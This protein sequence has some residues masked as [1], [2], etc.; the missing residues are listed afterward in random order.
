MEIPNNRSEQDKHYLYAYLIEII[1]AYEEGAIKAS[2]KMP[3]G[4]KNAAKV[5]LWKPLQGIEVITWSAKNSLNLVQD[6][7][8]D[9]SENNEPKIGTARFGLSDGSDTEQGETGSEGGT[10]AGTTPSPCD[11]DDIDCKDEAELAERE[12]KS[13]SISAVWDS[14]GTGWKEAEVCGYAPGVKFEGIDAK[15]ANTGKW[16][17]EGK[18]PPKW[19][20]DAKFGSDKKL[21]EDPWFM[22]KEMAENYE[23]YGD[24]LED[25]W[26]CFLDA[27]LSWEFPDV[28]LLAE[29]D[30]LLKQL[31]SL[32]DWIWDR[33]NPID[34]AKEICK[35]LDLLWNI[36][37]LPN[38]S[39]FLAAL[40]GLLQKY[41]I[42]GLSLRL[43][44]TGL[45]GPLVKMILDSLCSI[46][47]Q[48]VAIAMAPIKCVLNGL[49]VIQD[50]M[51]Q[52]AN[53]LN[54]TNQFWNYYVT[55]EALG[56]MWTGKENNGAVYGTKGRG[57]NDASW[58]EV[59]SGKN[60]SAGFDGW[61]AFG[62]EKAYKAASA[63][64]QTG[65]L[66]GWNPFPDGM[67]T[68]VQYGTKDT[69][70]KAAK[71]GD[72]KFARYLQVPILCL[73]EFIE[74]IQHMAKNIIYALKSLSSLLQ[75]QL[76]FSI[77]QSGLIMMV[78]D[79]IALIMALMELASHDWNC[80]D[81]DTFLE[82]LS[83][84]LNR[85]MSDVE[86]KPLTA[87]GDTH[88]GG[89]HYEGGESAMSN[90]EHALSVRSVGGHFEDVIEIN[91]CFHVASDADSQK[92]NEKFTQFF[93]EKMG[94]F[95]YE[96][97]TP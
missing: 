92:L 14:W 2:C 24:Y 51:G 11:D 94:P 81:M 66:Q 25:C 20:F 85:N 52:T 36:F 84:C 50:L 54:T 63:T 13:G 37:C 49:R 79:L 75:G 9:E 27:G 86:S 72:L 1:N 53:F 32:L 69:A 23:T 21:P 74:W 80:D 78:L 56:N 17:G 33:L 77:L 89:T 43:D 96:G 76:S 29:V 97:A 7:P 65:T 58:G 30:K 8:V 19:E 26:N 34:L 87:T 45:I 47:E 55:Q 31:E 83:E 73:Q 93:N 46:L 67:V 12:S 16:W 3:K 35:W 68:G 57:N 28:N 88:E 48:L 59:F 42:N 18:D 40:A 60:A 44:W 4:D 5:S 41:M 90:S 10:E 71:R 38:W 22:T 6:P 82:E 61:G 15:W 70:Y 64:K 62:D 91:S 39:M 95:G